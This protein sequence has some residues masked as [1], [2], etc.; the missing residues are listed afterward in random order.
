VKLTRVLVFGAVL[1]LAACGDARLR[2]L[3]V[4]ISKDSTMHLMGDKPDRA[5]AYLTGGKMIEALFYGKAGADS[6]QTPE[7][8]LTPVVIVDGQLTGWGR[9]EWLKVATEH[10][11]QIKTDS[12]RR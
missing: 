11:I 1:L 2:K 3:S 8:Q 5:E 4:G 7:A 10:R 9:D 12:V 6:G